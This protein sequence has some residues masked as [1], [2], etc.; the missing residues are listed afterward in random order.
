MVV[1]EGQD[2]IMVNVSRVENH[3]EMQKC[4]VNLAVEVEMIV[5]E[6]QRLVGEL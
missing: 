6:V 2:A 3:M 4:H 5:L 1:R